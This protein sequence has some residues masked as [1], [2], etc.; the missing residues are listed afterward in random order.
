MSSCIN[1]SWPPPDPRL[2]LCAPLQRYLDG[3]AHPRY[4]VRQGKH[5]PVTRQRNPRIPIHCKRVRSPSRATRCEGNPPLIRIDRMRRARH[6]NHTECVTR[7]GRRDGELSAHFDG[8][9]GNAIDDGTRKAIVKVRRIEDLHVEM[10]S[11][12]VAAETTATVRDTTVE[13]KES[14]GVII[15]RNRRRGQLGKG[16]GRRV[17]QFGHKLGGVVG[18]WNSRN[19][20]THDQNGAVR[21]DDRIAKGASV[22]HGADG[23][24]RGSS[25]GCADRDDVGVG[26]GLGVLVVW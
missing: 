10:I 11:S 4:P 9:T 26:G 3:L 5:H 13:Q 12:A 20:T 21:Q 16:I 22:G 18:E 8:S 7:P 1:F 2:C 19:L 15:A 25:G 24:N 17:E 14:S 23:L 6:A